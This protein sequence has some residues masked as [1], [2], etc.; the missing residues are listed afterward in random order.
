MGYR[1]EIQG[2]LASLNEYIAACRTNPYKGAKLKNKSEELVFEAIRSQLHGV[3]INKPIKV[4]YTW[5]EPNR[6]RDLD[7]V[8]SFGRK[9]I[10][11]ALVKA[12]VIKND[13]WDDIVGFSDNFKLDKKKPRI[14]IHIEEVEK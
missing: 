12:R 1:L 13:G 9:V 5:I 8:S 11:D 3:H 10:Q 4:E 14:E 7:N 6:K 2:R